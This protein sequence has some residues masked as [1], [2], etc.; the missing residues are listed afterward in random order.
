MPAVYPASEYV[1]LEELNPL[2]EQLASLIRAQQD[3]LYVLREGR[4][5]RSLDVERLLKA[6]LE[7]LGFWHGVTHRE[8]PGLFSSQSDF[9]IDFYHPVLQ[10]ALEIEK[11]K[12]FNV[13]RDVCKFAESSL[14]GHAILL[15]PYEKVSSQGSSDKIFSSTLDQLYNVKKLYQG[16]RSFLVIGY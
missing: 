10:A 4:Y 2:H 16:L 13:W 6:S 12:H 9:E 7:A 5:T 8:V 3:Q 11:G 1:H 14:I 15:I